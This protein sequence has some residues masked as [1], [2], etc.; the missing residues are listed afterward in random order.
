[1]N[2]VAAFVFGCYGIEYTEDVQN[3]LDGTTSTKDPLIALLAPLSTLRAEYEGGSAE[4]FLKQFDFLK[5]QGW[6]GIRRSRGDGDCFYRCASAKLLLHYP[7]V[8][9]GTE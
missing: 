6:E 5:N 2:Q 3:H 8:V 1:L 7:C 4:S 9:I